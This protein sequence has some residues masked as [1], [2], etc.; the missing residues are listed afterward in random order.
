MWADPIKCH[1]NPFL[2]S[3]EQRGTLIAALTAMAQ[4]IGETTGS[5][6]ESVTVSLLPPKELPTW[7]AGTTYGDSSR[8]ETLDYEGT[9]RD[10]SLPEQRPFGPALQTLSRRKIRAMRAPKKLWVEGSSWSPIAAIAEQQ[11]ARSRTKYLIKQMVFSLVVHGLL[12]CIVKAFL[13]HIMGDGHTPSGGVPPPD[14]EENAFSW[15][16]IF[17]PPE[18]PLS[19]DNSP[20]NSGEH[21]STGTTITTAGNTDD[22]FL[23]PPASMLP[24]A[25]SRIPHWAQPIPPLDSDGPTDLISLLILTGSSS[26]T[27]N[28]VDWLQS[29]SPEL[30]VY[31]GN[32]RPRALAP[33]PPSIVIESQQEDRDQEGIMSWE[34]A[35]PPSVS[36]STAAAQWIDNGSAGRYL[37]N[38]WDER[39]VGTGLGQEE[40][41]D[42]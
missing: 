8:C 3:E 42:R 39:L 16:M 25:N 21:M 35:Y 14:A 18:E 24:L 27:G 38:N 1:V 13:C 7:Q 11:K 40:I 19:P 15:L 34:M 32:G 10:P 20:H 29:D 23:S 33:T 5:P 6:V 2:S 41:T 22:T 26:R 12:H 36:G 4:K 30:P 31:A 17:I 28:T 9:Y 37:Q